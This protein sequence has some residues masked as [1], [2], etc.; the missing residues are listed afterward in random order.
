M[1]HR[2]TNWCKL[3]NV[4][5][6]Y[7]K[8][9]PI[10]PEITVRLARVPQLFNYRVITNSLE[11]AC[12][13]SDPATAYLVSPGPS[14]T[15][16]SSAERFF[17]PLF[18]WDSDMLSRLLEFFVGSAR[19]L[20]GDDPRL[21]NYTTSLSVHTPQGGYRL[22]YSEPIGIHYSNTQSGE[23]GAVVFDH[24]CAVVSPD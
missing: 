5:R 4:S 11:A 22:H 17:V 10:R 24:N 12:H 6:Q 14:V 19:P 18:T 7:V 15:T 3:E 1:R 20:D 2:Y 8:F 23:Q 16:I 21:A 9:Q 13:R